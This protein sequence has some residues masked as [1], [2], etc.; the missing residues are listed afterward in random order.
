MID[1]PTRC[2]HP[3][4]TGAWEEWIHSINDIVCISLDFD[5][6]THPVDASWTW[7]GVKGIKEHGV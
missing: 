4:Y 6:R 2:L 5:Y 1:I 3:R 7:G